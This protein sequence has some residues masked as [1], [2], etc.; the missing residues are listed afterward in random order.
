MITSKILY[1]VRDARG[2][3]AETLIFF[4]IHNEKYN[5]E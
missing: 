2:L 3:G 4:V 5:F 1:V